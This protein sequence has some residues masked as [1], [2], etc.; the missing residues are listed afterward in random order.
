[1]QACQRHWT[2][3]GSLRSVARGAGK[4]KSRKATA[5]KN[6]LHSSITK[7]ALQGAFPV[8]PMPAGPMPP[9]WP[10]G[11]TAA[12]AATI[13]KSEGCSYTADA[14][15]TAK[16]QQD[17]SMNGP[18]GA[19]LMGKT[20]PEGR[21]SASQNIPESPLRAEAL[22]ETEA[23]SPPPDLHAVLDGGG[24][25]AQHACTW[26]SPGNV[27]DGVCMW[28]PGEDADAPRGLIEPLNEMLLN[29]A[30][31]EVGCSILIHLSGA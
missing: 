20:F 13:L 26:E 30:P 9:T 19:Q 3:G 6:A 28:V 23:I 11:R 27:D 1:M 24:E 10:F 12:D 18:S 4:R 16:T 31:L 8:I 29:D 21:L 2:A 25:D 14:S 7:A 15:T 22:H 17:S 5:I